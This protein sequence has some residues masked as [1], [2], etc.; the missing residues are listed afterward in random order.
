MREEDYI[1]ATNKAKIEAAL[2]VLG[3][4]LPGDDYGITKMELGKLK[5]PVCD[6][7]IRFYKAISID[8]E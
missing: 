1:M 3:D 4:V 7:L 2:N 5:K 8:P 6:A